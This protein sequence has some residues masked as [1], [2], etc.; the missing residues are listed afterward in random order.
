MSAILPA[1]LTPESFQHYPPQARKLCVEHLELLR[2]LPLILLPLLLREAIAYDWRFPAERR[3]LNAQLAYLGGLTGT[4]FDALL[5]DFSRMTLSSDLTGSNWIDT[6][7]IFIEQLTSHLWATHQMDSFR[8][9]AQ[10]YAAAWQAASPPV[11]PA[12]PRLAIAVI[13]QGVSADK[14]SL[15][16]K[17]RPRGVYF[18]S[19]SERDGLS[20]LLAAVASR[21]SA[22]PG[23]YDHW[24]IDGGAAEG[25]ASGVTAVSYAGLE[26]SRTSLL[27][28]MQKV[29]ASGSAGPEALRTLMAQLKPQEIGLP[30]NGEAGVLG[31]FQLSLLTEGS[32]TQIF[33]TTFAQWAAREALRRAQPSTILVRFAPRQRQQP[34][35]ELLSGK[36]AS[37]ELDPEGSLID[38]DMGAYYTWLN[39]QRLS[40]A[41]RAGFVA[42]FEGHNQAVA[43]GPS[44]PHGTTSK[45]PATLSQLLEWVG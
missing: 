39:Q 45:T 23:S 44:L 3:E 22:H 37:N 19:V 35:N 10:D 2:R 16:R 24:Y 36:H 14:D 4:Q 31:H 5:A 7:S 40:G 13:G 26:A 25:L 21:A 43:I 30:D 18:T 29:I 28:R 20:T 27:N 9:A 15:F 42:W 8:A 6:P 17:L 32:G 12:Q 41:D 1:Q 34:M 33:S 38:A 11:P